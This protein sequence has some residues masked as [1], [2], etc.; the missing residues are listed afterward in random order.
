MFFLFVSLLIFSVIF[1]FFIQSFCIIGWMDTEVFAEWFERFSNQI[2][3]RPLLLLFDGHMTHVSLGVIK[4]ALEDDI[5][6]VKFPPHVTD[7]LQ[8]LDVSCFG[9]LKR[10]WEMLLQERVNLFAARLQLSKGD[11]VNQLCKIWRDGLKPD[12]IVSGFASTG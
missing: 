5:I 11:F 7:V 12:N 10:K 4:K 1:E 9:P 8:P 3:E 2:T 6:I